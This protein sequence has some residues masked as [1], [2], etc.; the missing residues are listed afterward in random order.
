MRNSL[1]DKYF[2]ITD[3][4]TLLYFNLDSLGFREDYYFFYDVLDVSFGESQKAY[5]SP[6]ISLTNDT[7]EVCVYFE[8]GMTMQDGDLCK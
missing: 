1:E 8:Y 5:L 7:A 3:I 4:T 6:T 2:C